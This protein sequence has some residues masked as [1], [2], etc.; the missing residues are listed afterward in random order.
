MYYLGRREN[1][2]IYVKAIIVRVNSES[3]YGKYAIYVRDVS[4]ASREFRSAFPFGISSPKVYSFYKR[5][6]RFIRI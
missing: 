5:K 2:L 4:L 6:L 3:F 1:K